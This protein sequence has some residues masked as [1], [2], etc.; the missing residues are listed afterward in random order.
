MQRM[1]SYRDRCM[2]KMSQQQYWEETRTDA[3]SLLTTTMPQD[4]LEVESKEDLFKMY[5]HCRKIVQD[6]YDI[7]YYNGGNEGIILSEQSFCVSDWILMDQILYGETTQ[8]LSLLENVP[9]EVFMRL[10][11]NVLPSGD[12]F[13]HKLVQKPDDR[14]FTVIA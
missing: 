8:V 1:R 13:F 5:F 11:F 7:D 9:S 3:N 4:E 2:Y 6:Y 10:F 14:V 12:T